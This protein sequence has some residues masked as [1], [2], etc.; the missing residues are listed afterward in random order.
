MDLLI[1]LLG[2]F[3]VLCIG[4][5]VTTVKQKKK[6]KEFEK[7]LRKNFGHFERKEVDIGNAFFLGD[8]LQQAVGHRHIF[9]TCGVCFKLSIMV[10]DRQDALDENLGAW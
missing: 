4:A 9:P 7:K 1:I 10:V 5:V 2:I 8:L 6:V 3:V